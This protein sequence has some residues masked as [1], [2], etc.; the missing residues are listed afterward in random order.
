LI[1]PCEV[2]VKTV[3][4]SIRALLAKTL[5]EKHDL[6]ET[7]VAEVLGITQSA[8]SKYY[9]NVRGITIPIENVAEIQNIISQM[10]TLLLTQSP[11]QEEL[12]KLFCQACMAIRAKGLMCS[13][14]QQ[15]QKIKIDNCDFC[16]SDLSKIY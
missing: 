3:S 10:V 6:K 1:I 16:N 9:K 7:Q 4:P 8:V 12:M 5:L 11:Q 15:N 13:L 14:C 2:A